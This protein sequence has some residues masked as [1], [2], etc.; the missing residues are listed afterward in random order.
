MLDKSLESLC[1]RT[2]IAGV[3]LVRPTP[4]FLMSSNLLAG[5]TLHGAVKISTWSSSDRQSKADPH[6]QRQML[7]DDLQRRTPA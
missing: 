6:D 1:T 7:A 2:G 4:D 3:A 5:I